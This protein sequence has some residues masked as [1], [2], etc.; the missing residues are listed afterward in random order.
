M[1]LKKQLNTI[2]LLLRFTVDLERLVGTA[3]YIRDRVKKLAFDHGIRNGVMRKCYGGRIEPLGHVEMNKLALPLARMFLRRAG[4]LG[5][6]PTPRPCWV[7]IN[8][9]PINANGLP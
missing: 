3:Q 7:T 2:I 6:P 1:E 4:S 5:I 8:Y 9:L